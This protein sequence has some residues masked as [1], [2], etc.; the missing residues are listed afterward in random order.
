MDFLA[1]LGFL[2]LSGATSSGSPHQYSETDAK[3]GIQILNSHNITL[4]QIV[5]NQQ[6]HSAH[7]IYL[8]TIIETG[9]VLIIIFIVLYFLH[10]GC[11]KFKIVQRTPSSGFQV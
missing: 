9:C 5:N 4:Q 11:K 7:F 8:E 10:R 3:T 1:K 2:L 6:E